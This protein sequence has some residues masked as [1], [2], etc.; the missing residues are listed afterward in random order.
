MSGTR[1]QGGD[2]RWVR[3]VLYEEQASCERPDRCIHQLRIKQWNLPSSSRVLSPMEGKVCSRDPYI[4]MSH[5]QCVCTV[6]HCPLCY[7]AIPR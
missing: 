5:V 7:A 2:M 4:C 3:E 1:T 6:D